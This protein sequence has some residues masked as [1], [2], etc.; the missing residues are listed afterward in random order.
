MREIKLNIGGMVVDYC[1]AATMAQSVA[2][3][4]ERKPTVIAWHD[5]VQQ[6][7][8]PTIEGADQERWRAYGA[9][10]GGDLSVSVN[11]D[12]DFIFADSGR[13]RE[14]GR[15]PYVA[16]HDHAGRQYLCPAGALRDPQ[17]PELAAC[18]VLDGSES[19][20]ALHEG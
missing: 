11:G 16:V 1:T 15:S 6:Q 12:Y 19:P 2:R 7:M 13:F 14:L 5:V 8:S 4:M 3:L 20:S 9:S 18:V 17:N 10:H